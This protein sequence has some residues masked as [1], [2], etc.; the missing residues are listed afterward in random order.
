MMMMVHRDTLSWRLDRSGL[1]EIN[2][3][4]VKGNSNHSAVNQVA[5]AGASSGRAIVGA[6]A[7]TL[8]HLGVFVMTFGL[9]CYDM[10]PVSVPFS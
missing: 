8:A 7:C 3:N 1:D 2:C 4:Q 10:T 9:L 6:R 5:S